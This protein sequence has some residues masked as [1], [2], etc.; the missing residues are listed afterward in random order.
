MRS[1]CID[2]AT[3]RNGGTKQVTLRAPEEGRAA[4]GTSDS[5]AAPSHD[6]APSAVGTRT[7]QG[8]Q[9]T[10]KATARP[11]L[12][13]TG[14]FNTESIR[15]GRVAPAAEGATAARC[16]RDTWPGPQG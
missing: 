15:L 5:H 4:G 11:Q 3:G 10:C 9:G 12:P 16:S 6:W 1:Q 8:S 14:H 13:A 7:G 2:G